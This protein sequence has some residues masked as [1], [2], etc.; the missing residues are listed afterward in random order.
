MVNRRVRLTEKERKEGKREAEVEERKRKGEA[1]ETI[2]GVGGELP[3][4][5]F[6]V[7]ISHIPDRQQMETLLKEKRT[8]TPSN[9][10]P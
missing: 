9:T 4:A 1:E 8:L 7:F 6:Q 10:T 2:W 5:F 3:Q